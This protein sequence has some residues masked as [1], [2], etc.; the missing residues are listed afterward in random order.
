LNFPAQTLFVAITNTFLLF[1]LLWREIT[2]EMK[3]GF[4]LK[5]FCIVGKRVLK[6]LC[7]NSSNPKQDVRTE[8]AER[9]QRATRK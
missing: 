5:Y 3:R 7:R 2:E 9:K 4:H 8:C 1:L 6:S